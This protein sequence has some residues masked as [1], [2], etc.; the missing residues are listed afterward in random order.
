MARKRLQ[1][2][3]VRASFR[4]RK[5]DMAA[6]CSAASGRRGGVS[7]SWRIAT[8]SY[9]FSALDAFVVK[10]REGYALV[11]GNRFQGGILPGAMPP[12][13]RYLEIRS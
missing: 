11:M 13:H 6:R 7:S 9:D 5:K 4:S 12:L 8:T 1:R 3:T 10:L 2:N